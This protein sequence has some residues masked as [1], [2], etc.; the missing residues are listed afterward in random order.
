MNRNESRVVIMTIL[1]QI[2]IFD[3]KKIIYDI[4]SVI[5]ENV[6]ITNDFVNE[7]VHGVINNKDSIDEIANKYLQ[8]WKINRLGFPDQAILRMAIYEMK[9]TD[10]PGIVCINE[11][12][13]L[14]KIYSDDKVKNMINGVLD[15]IYHDM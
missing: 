4:D 3:S 9:Y 15:N 2:F 8:D 1:Y 5:K 7:V 11:A 6:E 10:T 12:V 14:S 13:E